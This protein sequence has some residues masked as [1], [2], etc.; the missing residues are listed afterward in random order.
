MM[1]MEAIEALLALRSPTFDFSP[2]ITGI[3]PI[4]SIT[5]KRIMVAVA[6]DLIVVSMGAK[7]YDKNVIAVHC[8]SDE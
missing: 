4:T 7:V 1:S 8:F 6:I 2:M 5:A 3:E